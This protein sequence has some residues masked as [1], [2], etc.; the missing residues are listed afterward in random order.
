MAGI[1][2]QNSGQR[3][4][5]PA[6][7]RTSGA[8]ENKT[9]DVPVMIFQG[10]YKT[11]QENLP[12]GKGAGG[13]SLWHRDGKKQDKPGGDGSEGGGLGAQ[14]GRDGGGKKGLNL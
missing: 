13:G 3:S 12:G 8:R 14:G 1:D 9:F 11:G 4:F 2:I 6:V 7:Y 5:T 10:G